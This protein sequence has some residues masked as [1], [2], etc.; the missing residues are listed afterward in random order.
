MLFPFENCMSHST[1]DFPLSVLTIDNQFNIH[2][3]NVLKQSYLPVDTQTLWSFSPYFKVQTVAKPIPNGESVKQFV[4]D[5]I[6]ILRIESKTSPSEFGM[7][8]F[9]MRMWKRVT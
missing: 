5:E 8:H 2:R 7:Q 9:P 1:L 6:R 4:D 3:Q